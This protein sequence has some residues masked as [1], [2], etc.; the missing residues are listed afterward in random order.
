MKLKITKEQLAQL[1]DS[2]K[3]S[4]VHMWIPEKYDTAVAYVCKSVE[5]DEYE[6]IEFVIG[7]IKLYHQN[8]M[9][10]F[11]ITAPANGPEESTEK[12]DTSN[13][14]ESA[15]EDIEDSEEAD[16]EYELARPVCFSKES[17]L[18]ILNIGQM[19]DILQRNNFRAGEFHLVASS[20]EIGCE[21]GKQGAGWNA[22]GIEIGNSELCDVLWELVKEI[23]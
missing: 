4:L 12:E 18:P 8:H 7:D 3:Q 5:E 22:Y 9:V 13:I 2:Q 23:F 20:N 1:T 11:D 17:C 19:I 21:L 15:E 16:F 10:L 6:E 14:D